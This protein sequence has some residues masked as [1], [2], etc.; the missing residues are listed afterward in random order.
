MKHGLI[1]T[2]ST[3]CYI[4]L[5]YNFKCKLFIDSIEKLCF[6]IMSHSQSQ[7][8]LLKLAKLKHQLIKI[9]FKFRMQVK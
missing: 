6:K 7:F 3:Y 4:H 2:T 1:E 5:F 9:I 8:Q